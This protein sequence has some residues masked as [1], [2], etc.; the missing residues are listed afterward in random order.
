MLALHLTDPLS[1]NFRAKKCQS[2]HDIV[3]FAHET[4]VRA[5]FDLSD[6]AVRRKQQRTWRLDTSVP[7]H[8]TLMDLGGAVPQAA[9]VRSKLKPEEVLSVPFQALWRGVQTPNL[10]WS[11]RSQVSASGFMS[12]VATSAVDGG[13]AVR[14]LGDRNYAIVA[15]EYLNLNARLAYHFAMVDAMVGNVPENNY[16]NFRFRGGGAGADRRELR[17]RFLAEVLLRSNFGV[18]RRGDLVTAWLH[19]HPQSASE[20]GLALLGRLMACA[21]QLDMLMEG[22]QSV[23]DFVNRFLGGDYESFA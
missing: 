21:R 10:S 17:A 6:E 23:H 9:N 2:V 5:M 8:L 1:R 12:V 16:I 20:E 19:R 14:R 7:L 13:G 18:D 3:R 22:E 11:G 4:A 15:R